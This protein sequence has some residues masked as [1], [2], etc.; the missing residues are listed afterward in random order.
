MASFGERFR[1]IRERRHFTQAEL[2]K[3]ASTSVSTISN[4]ERTGR[5]DWRSSTTLAIYRALQDRILLSTEE[6]E[7]FS[8][9]TGVKDLPFTAADARRVVSPDPTLTPEQAQLNQLVFNLRELLRDDLLISCLRTM[10]SVF[11]AGHK[12]GMASAEIM[13]A[14]AKGGVSPIPSATTIVHP[15]MEGILG[16]EIVANPAPTTTKKART[17]RA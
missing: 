5:C 8:E 4:L 1:E 10:Q 6:R 11:N 7:A 9:G 14:A 16:R 3:A 13:P 12:L 2:A 17:R 15:E